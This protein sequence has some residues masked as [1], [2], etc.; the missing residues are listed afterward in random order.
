MAG[1]LMH[2]GAIKE[3]KN[4]SIIFLAT[5]LC[6]ILTRPEAGRLKSVT[7]TTFTLDP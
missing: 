3:S 2:M 1:Y 7:T 4:G 6:K 5:A